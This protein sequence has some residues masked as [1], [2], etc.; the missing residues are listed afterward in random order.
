MSLHVHIPTREEILP[1]GKD[2]M[3]LAR[4]AAARHRKMFNMHPSTI[5]QVPVVLAPSPPPVC[6]PEPVVKD[7]RDRRFG[8]HYLDLDTHQRQGPVNWAALGIEPTRPAYA[9]TIAQVQDDVCE[10]L[11]ITLRDLLMRRRHHAVVRPRQVAIWLCSKRTT[12]SLPEIGRR[13]GGMDHTSIM[14]ANEKVASVVSGNALDVDNLPIGDAARLIL[15]A[16]WS[17]KA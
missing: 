2:P 4:E 12:K 14:N 17:R 13:F 5:R 7:N 1:G 9:F 3:T 10:A 15:N 6:E 8:P 11:N 16:D